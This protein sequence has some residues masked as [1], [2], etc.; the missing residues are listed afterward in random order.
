MPRSD[1][2]RRLGQDGSRR[3]DPHHPPRSRRGDQLHRHRGRV[4][5]R[6][7]RADRRQGAGRRPAR[8]RRAR[9]QGPRHDGRRSERVRELAPLD[10]QGGR[11][12]PAE[13]RDRLDRPVPDP[14]SRGRY[15]HRRDARRAEGPRARGQG[16]VHRL[17]DVP[18]VADRRGPVGRRAARSR[19]VR[20]RAAAL[21]D[22][23]AGRRIRRAPDLPA[24][25]DGRDPVEPARGRVALRALPARAGRPAVAGARR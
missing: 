12:Q 7:I 22:A 16:P 9:D 6:R 8:Q 23:R 17:L 18:G 25:W 20:V 15:R 24:S 13:A 11:E 4:L 2:V 21:L 3:V 5:P 14:P 1:D 19:A 10:R